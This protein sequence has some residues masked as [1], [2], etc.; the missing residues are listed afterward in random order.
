MLDDF[1]GQPP[2]RKVAGIVFPITGNVLVC[3]VLIWHLE[4]LPRRPRKAVPHQQQE[5]IVFDNF[6]TVGIVK[7]FIDVSRQGQ[8]GRIF[9]NKFSRQ[10][11][12][13]RQPWKI[14]PLRDFDNAIG[15]NGEEAI[16]QTHVVH[17]PSVVYIVTV[18]VS[19]QFGYLPNRNTIFVTIVAS[20]HR[21]HLA[22]L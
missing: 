21:D 6:H 10:S 1:I 2:Q 5:H 18:I 3:A 13:Q 8:G 22:Y 9:F 4:E 16:A 11:I 19:S 20:G 15:Y 17:L 12:E 14:A 7:Q